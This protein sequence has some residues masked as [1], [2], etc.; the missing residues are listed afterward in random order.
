[1]KRILF[2]GI[3]LFLLASYALAGSISIEWTQSTSPNITQ[4]KIYWGISPG[5]Y[6]NVVTIPAATTH[7]I[8]SLAAG[9]YYI[10]I[11]AVDSAGGESP[12]SNEVSGTVAAAP[13]QMTG[14]TNSGISGQPYTATLTAS[15]G[16]APYSFSIASGA[17]PP[18]LILGANG[19]ISGTPQ[20]SGAYI[21]TAQ[22]TD[23]MTVTATVSCKITITIA[24]P[25]GLRI[26]SAV[27]YNF[28]GFGE[29]LRLT[30]NWPVKAVL[31]YG[32]ASQD[33]YSDTIIA[34]YNTTFHQRL[35]FNLARQTQYKYLWTVT[36]GRGNRAERSGTFY[37]S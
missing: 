2:I 36:D 10:A 25:G 27:A 1:M 26:T 33:G 5:N 31:Q 20:A 14:I 29:L 15:G 35:L 12:F 18:G 30:T 13:L 6:A 8:A 28:Y 23:S 4:N 19:V 11:T 24:A 34:P 22:V 32:K 3:F 16:T 37:R 7:T 17:L 21:F 9:T